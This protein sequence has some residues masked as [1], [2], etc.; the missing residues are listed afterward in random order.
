VY[1]LVLF[2]ALLLGT[3]ADTMNYPL[4][5]RV[6]LVEVN[7]VFELSNK[8]YK[9]RYLQLVFYQYD[10]EV[11]DYVAIDWESLKTYEWEDEIDGPSKYVLKTSKPYSII[12]KNGEW[13]FRFTGTVASVTVRGEGVFRFTHIEFKDV[14][15]IVT[16]PQ[17]IYRQTIGIDSYEVNYAKYYRRGFATL[18]NPGGTFLDQVSEAIT[19][20]D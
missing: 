1:T 5:D 12:D 20:S 10:E 8:G 19:F 14:P 15:R 7:E 13:E 16:T 6:D 3:N 4:E 17:V 11:A 2:S 18:Q 9:D